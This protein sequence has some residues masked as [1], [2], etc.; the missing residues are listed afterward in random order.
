[1]HLVA[2]DRR[3]PTLPHQHPEAGR[4]GEGSALRSWKP[5]AQL[6]VKVLCIPNS[7]WLSTS[8][9]SSTSVMLQNST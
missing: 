2:R 6:T 1:M 7:K 3:T 5:V 8:P 9:S 4:W